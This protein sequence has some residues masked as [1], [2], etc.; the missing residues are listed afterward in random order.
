MNLRLY[1]IRSCGLVS[2]IYDAVGIY[3]SGI[4]TDDFSYKATG[5]KEQIYIYIQ[6]YD[7]G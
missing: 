1:H 6:H 7:G 2:I 5:N 4:T 3:I